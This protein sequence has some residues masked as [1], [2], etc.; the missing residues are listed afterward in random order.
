M[1]VISVTG[2]LDKH[3][4]FIAHEDV[5]KQDEMTPTFV[6]LVWMTSVQGWA[7]LPIKGNPYPT[8]NACEIV[9]NVLIRRKINKVGPYHFSD[10]KCEKREIE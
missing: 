4:I 3:V 1:S 6:L 5:P 10:P 7:V 9:R 2:A 8:F